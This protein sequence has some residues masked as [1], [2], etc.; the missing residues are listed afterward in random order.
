MAERKNNNDR[1]NNKNNKGLTHTLFTKLA[2]F[3]NYDKDG[4]GVKKRK[5]TDKERYSLKSFFVVYKNQFWNLIILNLIYML[6]LSPV[7][8]G[9]LAYTGVFSTRAPGPSNI[10][11]AP[12]Y[13]IHL[14][15]PTPATTNLLGILGTQMTV[16]SGNT[17]MNVLYGI[18]LLIFLTFG[19][20]NAG[21]TYVLR[22]YTRSEYAYLWHDFFKTIK[23]NF[24]GAMVLGF[25]DLAVIILLVLST[26]YYYATPGTG[27]T[28]LFLIMFAMSVI[29]FM[30]RFYLYILLITFKLSPFKLI[31]NAFILALLG[32]KRNLMA[33][34]GIAVLMLI[35]V[36]IFM[37]SLPFGITLPF[38]LLMSNGAFISCFAAYP[39]VKKYMI[40]PYYTEHPEKDKDE[41]KIEDEPI[42]I[43]RG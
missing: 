18:A 28:F 40:D 31:K 33:I 2:G 10:L 21:M 41:L 36:V 6:M 38:F 39:N 11:Y 35:Y 23:K 32:I 19:L 29:Y 16:V 34:L 37:F 7:I 27:N 9:L 17:L 13:G 20:A 25:V 14:C 1:N 4:K 43:D 8:C 15:Y 42:F 22:A 24:F 3:S 30:M 26:Y 12:I 5:I